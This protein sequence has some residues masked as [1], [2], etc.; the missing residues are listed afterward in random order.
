MKPVKVGYSLFHTTPKKS[1][2]HN[3]IGF[4]NTNQGLVRFGGLAL[5][6]IIVLLF[7][8]AIKVALKK[9]TQHLDFQRCD[10]YMV[11]S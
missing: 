1:R 7:A 10:G 3:G 4:S 11:S 9:I 5:A 8:I 2:L 6:M